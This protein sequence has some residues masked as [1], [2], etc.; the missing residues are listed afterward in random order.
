MVK[1]VIFMVLTYTH[2][3]N[4]HI[5]YNDIIMNGNKSG[6]HVEGNGTGAAYCIQLSG[7]QGVNIYYNN[8]STSNEDQT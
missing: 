3:N 4:I 8:L 5:A 7:Q 2:V 1:Q 6:G